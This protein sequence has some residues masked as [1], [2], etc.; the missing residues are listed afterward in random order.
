M[1]APLTSR[2][3]A[4]T[5]AWSKLPFALASSLFF[6][7]LFSVA[8][9]AAPKFQ[10]N[11]TGTLRQARESHTGTLLLDG[12]VLVTGGLGKQGV[13]SP[14]LDTAELYD[15]VTGTWSMTGNL[16]QART[17]HKAT[18]LPEGKVLI[19]GGIG[20]DL[21]TRLSSAELYDPDSG[22]FTATGSMHDR[23]S[24]QLAVELLDGRVLVA[25]GYDGSNALASAEIYDP[26]SGTWSVTGNLNLT[27]SAPI[28]VVLQSGQVL[29]MGG[30]TSAYQSA[31]LY[32]PTTG[33]WTFTGSMGEVRISFTATLLLDGRVLVASGGSL[34]GMN[35]SCE[36]YDP[37]T[38]SWSETGEMRMAR[39]G[40][41]AV[42]LPG[43]G[44]LVEGG[45]ADGLHGLRYPTLAE[46]YNPNTG[47]WTNGGQLIL[48]RFAHSTNLLS[49]GRVLV[50][51]GLSNEG[52]GI[53]H[54]CELATRLSSSGGR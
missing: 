22:Q 28:G 45:Q 24:S 52:A 30:N 29:I 1:K 38:G 18:L 13:F 48:G 9:A 41:E 11:D 33:V 51:G 35:T 16:A 43:G 37:A 5:A 25:G 50:A 3:S 32:D 20:S 26:A 49:D 21:S 47:V 31:E 6:V 4:V 15:P 7:S 27:R 14:V 53:I 39:G 17:Q 2:R 54:R 10:W 42:L 40:H 23:R 36:L 12:Q 44:I 34:Q 19:T 8:R 46:V